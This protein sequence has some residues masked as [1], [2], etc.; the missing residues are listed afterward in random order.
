M[1]GGH[2]APSAEPLNP[3]L[4]PS[5]QAVD[6]GEMIGLDPAFLSL[7]TLR[8]LGHPESPMKAVRVHCVRCCGGSYA[9]ANKCTATSC[10][11][12]AYRMGRNPFHAKSKTRF[13]TP[14]K[15]KPATAATVRASNLKTSN[16]DEGVLSNE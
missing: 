9:E 16:S 15:M 8:G 12:W 11:L 5:P 2:I 13:Q 1:S 7:P 4:T 3:Y 10:A 14:S 6:R